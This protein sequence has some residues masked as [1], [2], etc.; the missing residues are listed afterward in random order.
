MARRRY[1]RAGE[2]DDDKRQTTD[3]SSQKR[4]RNYFA[5]TTTLLKT[6]RCRAKTWAALAPPDSACPP[7]AQADFEL[8]I[9]GLCVSGNAHLLLVDDELSG[10]DRL[11]KKELSS[12]MAST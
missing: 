12:G 8:V 4:L 7:A 2:G 1:S 6:T 3:S 11:V 9:T 5:S 10:S